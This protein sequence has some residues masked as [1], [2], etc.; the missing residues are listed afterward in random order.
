MIPRRFRR[1]SRAGL[2][3]VYKSQVKK[4]ASIFGT[5]WG[6]PKARVAPT[7]GLPLSLGG[8]SAREKALG[9]AATGFSL[10]QPGRNAGRAITEIE[11]HSTIG[12]VY[13][14]GTGY[15]GRF[16]LLSVTPQTT[17]YI[18]DTDSRFKMVP[19]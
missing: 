12:N 8:S 15:P 9:Q 2:I 14:P 4:I 5:A 6:G 11:I 10:P 17:V 7:A 1:K 13:Y 3:T 16:V 18:S 19:G